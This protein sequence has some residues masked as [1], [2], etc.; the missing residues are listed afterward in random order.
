MVKDTADDNVHGAMHISNNGFDL[1]RLIKN[2]RKRVIIGMNEQ[3]SSEVRAWGRC[4][5]E[6]SAPFIMIWNV[7]PV[8]IRV[9][10]KRTDSRSYDLA[11]NALP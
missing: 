5:V 11:E 8:R 1:E 10:S 4:L 6:Q 3:A 9:F 2:L 7:S